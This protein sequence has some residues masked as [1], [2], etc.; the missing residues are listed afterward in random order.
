MSYAWPIPLGAFVTW[1]WHFLFFSKI[2]DPKRERELQKM[3]Q[4]LRRE[5][6][7]W[8]D[9]IAVD[10]CN[11]RGDSVSC[12]MQ[13]KSC[14]SHVETSNAEN[15]ATVYLIFTDM[16]A[17]TRKWSSSHFYSRYI[18]VNLRLKYV[19][20]PGYPTDTPSPPLSLSILKD[21]PVHQYAQATCDTEGTSIILCVCSFLEHSSPEHEINWRGAQDPAGT[22]DRCDR[23][24]LRR[25]CVFAQSRQGL[26]H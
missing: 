12:K 21:F 7:T 17:R 16:P 2:P 25:A 3:R 13:R 11:T 19:W 20:F 23:R 10:V 15:K 5:R 6:M 22:Y 4:S 24:R 14:K 8:V 26:A 18:T 9:V 1:L